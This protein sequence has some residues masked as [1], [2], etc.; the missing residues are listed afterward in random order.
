MSN[1]LKEFPELIKCIEGGHIN[2]VKNAIAIGNS[3]FQIKEH[4]KKKKENW[5]LFIQENFDVSIRYCQNC[6]K[7]A[8]T[9]IHE[10]HYK[11][12]TEKLLELI[13][14]GYTLSHPILDPYCQGC[15]SYSQEVNKWSICTLDNQTG[16]CPCTKCP[17][18][19]NDCQDQ[20]NDW[21]GWSDEN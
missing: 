2:A 14:N 17:Q 13:R 9:E 8:K 21:Y 5:T 4:V 20:C 15:N 16:K 6:M 12:G 18:K 11:H 7:L 19:I 10:N 1:L 3:L